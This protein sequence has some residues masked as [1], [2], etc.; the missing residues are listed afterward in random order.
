MHQHE[1]TFPGL[2]PDVWQF[3]HALCADFRGS[4][5]F[6]PGADWVTFLEDASRALSVQIVRGY[7]FSG[8]RIKTADF[9]G[10]TTKGRWSRIRPKVFNILGRYPEL[11]LAQVGTAFDFNVGEHNDDASLRLVHKDLGIGATQSFSLAVASGL[12]S[13]AADLLS[14][15]AP[16]VGNH[17]RPEW[18]CA[19]TIPV[20]LGAEFYLGDGTYIG[21][22]LK[23]MSNPNTFLAQHTAR[24]NRARVRSQYGHDYAKGYVREVFEINLLSDAHM[25]APLN[26][27]S[28]RHYTAT[29]GTLNRSSFGELWDWRLK[30]EELQQARVDWEDSGLVLSAERTPINL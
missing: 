28:V 6:R 4:A 17:I 24:V 26:G 27:G 18:G 16:A 14:A 21:S 5:W 20:A 22:E 25:N 13:T 8:R 7:A 3:G 10:E 12:A 19:F 15:L 9:K 11:N 23:S 1:P 2:Q 29:H 30:P